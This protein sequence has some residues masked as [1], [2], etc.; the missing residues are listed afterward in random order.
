MS[1]LDRTRKALSHHK[2]A[3]TSFQE[4]LQ[5]YYSQSLRSSALSRALGIGA[6]GVGVG[7]GV[8]GLL[9]LLNLGKGN[10]SNDDPYSS[11][12]IDLG[13][14]EE[15]EKEAGAPK[16]G[17]SFSSSRLSPE[18]FKTKHE[19]KKKKKRKKRRKSRD[20]ASSW[21]PWMWSAE[22]ERDR[23]D[24][25]LKASNPNA[26]ASMDP[27]VASRVNPRLAPGGAPIPK[28][29]QPQQPLTSYGERGVHAKPLR[30]FLGMSSGTEKGGEWSKQAGLMDF[31]KGQYA[32][33]TKGVPWAMPAAVGAG[34]G[35]LYGGWKLMDYVLDQR[36]KS[37]LDDELEE[38]KAEY[39]AALSGSDKVA[40]D[41]SL[42]S[43]LDQLYNSI[44]DY[45]EKAA[46]SWPEIS[47][48]AMGVYGTGAGVGALIMALIGYKQG[49][50]KQRK[51]ILERAQARRRREEY[52]RRPD[53][54]YVR[55]VGSGSAPKVDEGSSDASPSLDEIEDQLI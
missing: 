33:T 47:G 26:S 5:N 23:L 15:E 13:E 34:A 22:R 10:I 39:E 28:T 21:L 36:R 54:L 20:K 4:A 49:K 12:L 17:I 38:A 46:A 42:A 50:K 35:G 6:T 31:L 2:Q 3:E 11:A 48:Q 44:S 52:A 8:R 19:K 40:A 43:D 1:D 53:P 30:S 29:Q 24:A 7:L 32:E 55:E 16:G 45:G 25:D 9:G 14:E 27:N 41:G 51:T 37:K 18:E